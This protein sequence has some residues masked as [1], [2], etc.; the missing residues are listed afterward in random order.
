MLDDALPPDIIRRVQES[1][2]HKFTNHRSLQIALLP[3]VLRVN[4]I[5][6]QRLAWVGDFT[7]HYCTSTSLVKQYKY[8]SMKSLNVL[9]AV[10]V[11]RKVCAHRLKSV[12]AIE[13]LFITEKQRLNVHAEVLEAILGAVAEDGGHNAVSKLLHLHW[14]LP[15]SCGTLVAQLKKSKLWL[16]APDY[17]SFDWSDPAPVGEPPL[18]H[19]VQ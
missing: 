16:S 2:R 15:K 11:S 13:A 17:T 18:P 4:P 5:E 10:L 9:R 6:F 19:L 3:A 12:K 7:L 14:P 1:L 8:I